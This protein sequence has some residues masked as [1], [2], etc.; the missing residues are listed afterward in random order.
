MIAPK[1]SASAIDEVSTVN[2][3]PSVAVPLIVTVPVGTWLTL[4][5]ALVAA[6]VMLSLVPSPSVYEAVPVICVPTSAWVSV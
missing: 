1:P 4:T 6:L 3:S 5:T 2:V